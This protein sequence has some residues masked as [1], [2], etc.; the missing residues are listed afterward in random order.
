VRLVNSNYGWSGGF[1]LDIGQLSVKIKNS[2]QGYAV[3]HLPT[4]QARSTLNATLTKL[5]QQEE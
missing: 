1:P 4:H 5:R 3:T 2:G